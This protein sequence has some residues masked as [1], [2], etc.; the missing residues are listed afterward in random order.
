MAEKTLFQKFLDRVAARKCENGHELPAGKQFCPDCGKPQL[1]VVL[2]EAERLDEIEAVLAEM[3]NVGA[4]PDK[5]DDESFWTK[6]K[7]ALN[8]DVKLPAGKKNSK[9]E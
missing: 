1:A 5:A 6:V 2:T 7:N 3:L 8:S 9:K 4:T